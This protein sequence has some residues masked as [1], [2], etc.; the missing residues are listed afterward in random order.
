[1][2]EYT[3]INEKRKKNSCASRYTGG[4]MKGTR[5]VVRV[6][7]VGLLCFGCGVLFSF[8]MPEAML[9]VIESVVIAGVG[10]IYFSCR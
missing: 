7:G 5:S 4:A 10:L 3:D 8:F 6:L 1:M 9:I 2:R